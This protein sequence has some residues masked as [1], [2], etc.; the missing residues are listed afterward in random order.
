[1]TWEMD[2]DLSRNLFFVLIG[3]IWASFFVTLE[4][5][6]SFRDKSLT[7]KK[8]VSPF[9]VI[10]P[11]HQIS[12]SLSPYAEENDSSKHTAHLQMVK[13]LYGQFQG[14]CTSTIFGES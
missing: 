6:A 2:P 3:D 11:F 5:N 12:I 8:V 9:K 13:K 4:I 14:M 1:M 7:T 10:D